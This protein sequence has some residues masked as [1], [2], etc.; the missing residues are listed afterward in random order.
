MGTATAN[1]FG[2]QC[3]GTNGFGQNL[4]P[5]AVTGLASGVTSVSGGTAPA[6]G[7]SAC[8]VMGGAVQ[9]WGNNGAGQLGNGTTTSSAVPVPV[10]TLTSGVTSVSVGFGTACAL[11]SGGSVWCWGSG[12]GAVPLRV[13][14]FPQ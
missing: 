6:G 7:D 11:T 4:T 8:A 12:V 2:V 1:R 14:G 13:P 3:W 5:A 9:C 10:S